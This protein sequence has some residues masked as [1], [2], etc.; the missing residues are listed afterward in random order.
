MTG[1]YVQT[2]VAKPV[3]FNYVFGWAEIDVAGKSVSRFEA[4]SLS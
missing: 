3:T 1:D 2:Q 4:V